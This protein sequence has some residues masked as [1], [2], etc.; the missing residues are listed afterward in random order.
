[1]LDYRKTLISQYANSPILCQIIAQFNDCIDPR[2]NLQQFYDV[3]WN[4]DTAQGVG[5]DI[6]GRIVGIGR[7]VRVTLED[8]Y[9]GYTQG[10][11]PFNDGIWGLDGEANTHPVSMDDA[12]YRKVI[13]LKAMSNI[14]Y[15]T[16]PNI[17]R[18]LRTMFGKRG[19]TY[20]MK[21]GTMTARYV[22]E[23]SL[24]P[25]ERAI[26]QQTDLLPRPSGVLIDFDELDIKKTFGYQNSDLA[27]FGEGAF[28]MGD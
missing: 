17:N 20:F 10:F 16:A 27:P 12:T 3:I 9:L 2:A 1:M 28:F 8:E 14:I 19:R 15:A 25:L 5:L 26:I 6:W 7:E 23:F 22:F 11:T 13:M 24:L 4:V 21:T 18:L